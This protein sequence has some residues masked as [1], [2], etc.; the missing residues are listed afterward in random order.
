M[1]LAEETAPDL[2][3]GGAD[4]SFSSLFAHALRGAPCRVLGLDGGPTDLPVHEW[5]RRADP[6]D[7]ALLSHC[8]GP[9]LDVGCG[10]GRLAARLAE[11]GERV[12]GLDVVHEAVEQTRARGVPAVHASVF[13]PV[14]GEGLWTTA[15]LA[16]GNIGIGGDPAALVRRLRDVVAP[17][18]RIVVELAGPGVPTSTRWARLEAAGSLSRPFRWSVVGLDGVADLAASAGLRVAVRAPFGD[19]RWLAVLQSPT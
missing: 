16:D 2:R 7:D 17:G 5:T 1:S 19:G 6:A 9:T 11:R 15:L 3:R 14:P 12:L 18:G 4:R 13:D 10:P 8:H